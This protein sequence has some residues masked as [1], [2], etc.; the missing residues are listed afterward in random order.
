MFL[1][2]LKR[3]VICFCS[4][5]TFAY[6]N[7]ECCVLSLKVL[8]IVSMSNIHVFFTLA[9]A[10]GSGGVHQGRQGHCIAAVCGNDTDTHRRSP[11]CFPKTDE[12]GQA[13]YLCGNRQ[14][15]LCV[16]AT[17]ET[18]HGPHHHQEQQHPG[19]PRDTQT[20]LP[21]GKKSCSWLSASLYANSLC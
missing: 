16:P 6:S 7:C 3:C 8:C 14:C 10:V 12:H 11:G 4:L 2:V 18:L 1:L 13:A 19:G 21:C 15:S 20:F 9:G 5:G 17:G